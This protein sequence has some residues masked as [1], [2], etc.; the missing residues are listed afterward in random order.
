MADEDEDIYEFMH[1]SSSSSS[2]R[3]RHRN[4]VRNP[5]FRASPLPQD[6]G[7]ISSRM[8]LVQ[9]GAVP[10]RSGL[11]TAQDRAYCCCV[12]MWLVV[13]AALTCS[14]LIL[15]IFTAHRVSSIEPINLLEV[16]SELLAN[17][18]TD[19]SASFDTL[20]SDLGATSQALSLH[21]SLSPFLS[22]SSIFLTNPSSPSGYYWV[23]ASDGSAVR[24]Y[25]DMSR[26][27]G[28]VTGGWVRVASLDFVNMSA[29]CPDG[30]RG[31]NDSDISTCG[32][33]STSPAC[34]SVMFD[35][36]NISYTRVCGRMLAYQ[37]GTTNAFVQNAGTSLTIDSN[38][39]D[40]V[41]LTHGSN[42]RH[43]IWTFAAALDEFGANS[44]DVCSCSNSQ[45]VG[46]SPPSFV[47]TGDYFCDSGVAGQFDSSGTGQFFATSPLWDGAGCSSAST[48]CSFNDPP[49]FHKQLLSST[50][51]DI[52]MRACINKG[53]SLVDIALSLVEIYVQ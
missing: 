35:T 11:F 23:R 41:S 30:F 6:V 4:F 17:I 51:N 21:L 3:S 31:H 28:N 13:V 27:C 19:V 33:D 24:V 52:E 7:T 42:P 26:S 18:S 32:I 38:Y 36:Y 25:C 15:S 5:S 48:C 20:Q 10:R 37:Y 22:C 8:A 2:S 40:G 46:A 34:A 39:V 12:G 16:K 47:S 50:S 49:W 53:N 29:P 43:H 45:R 1:P 14:S 9:D 44:G